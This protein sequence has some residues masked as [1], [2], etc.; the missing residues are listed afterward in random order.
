MPLI[1]VSLWQNIANLLQNSH[2]FM[3]IMDPGAAYDASTSHN[4]QHLIQIIRNDIPYSD[5][6]RLLHTCPFNMK[7]WALFLHLNERSLQRYRKD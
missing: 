5:F 6:D 1:I 2:L 4:S 7:D 3:V